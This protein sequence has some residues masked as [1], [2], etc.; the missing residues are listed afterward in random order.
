MHGAAAAAAAAA[1]VELKHVDAAAATDSDGDDDGDDDGED[2]KTRYYADDEWS[3]HT[4][5]FFSKSRLPHQLW[6]WST[7]SVM[8]FTDAGDTMRAGGPYKS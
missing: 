3:I 6:F 7:Y 4:P 2:N 8:A 5:E 1:A